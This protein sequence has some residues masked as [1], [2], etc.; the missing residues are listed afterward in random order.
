M[1]TD[2]LLAPLDAD[3]TPEAGRLFVDLV[4]SYLA[5]TFHGDGPVSTAHTPEEL[6]ARFD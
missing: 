5:E 4:A 2:P 6:A 3:A 1:T